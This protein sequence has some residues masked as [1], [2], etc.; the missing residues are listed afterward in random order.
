MSNASAVHFLHNK[1]LNFD[2]YSNFQKYCS[3]PWCYQKQFLFGDI[4]VLSTIVLRLRQH[5]TFY[6]AFDML[7]FWSLRYL[8]F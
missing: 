4:V 3:Q 1:H 8:N 2:I 7:G 5:Y 6:A